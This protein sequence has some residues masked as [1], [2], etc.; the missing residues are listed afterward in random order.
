MAEK[1][2]DYKKL[3][4]DILAAVGGE[5]NITSV[6][7]CATRLRL[8]LKN[9]TNEMKE[10]V[11]QMP[12]VI[13]VVQN[14]GQFQIVIGQHVTD[15][16]D[17]FIQLV[18]SDVLEDTENQPKQSILNRVIATMSA[19]FAPFIYILAAAGI[20]QGLLIIINLFYSDFSKTGAYQVFSFMSWA[21][22]VFLP[23]FIAVTASKHFK[24]NTFV[25]LACCA[26]LVSPDWAN[27]AGQIA[28]GH[29]IDFFGIPLTQTVYTSSVIPPL[30]LVWLLSYLEKF[31]NKHVP[32]V[33]KELLVP[34]ISLVVMVPLTIILIGPISQWAANGVAD[35]YNWLVKIA[36]PVAG[37][38]IGGFWE[39]FVIFGV[40]WGITPVVL[41]NFDM[42]GMDSF[43]AFQTAAVVSQVGAALGVFFKSKNKELKTVSLSA[44][45]TGIFGI[46]E[47]TIY[48]VT[49]KFKRP[50]I[51][52]CITGALG[53]LT[54][55]LF[56]SH[57]FAYAGLPGMLTVVNGIS[58]KYPS[59]FIGIVLGCLVAFF[60][61]MILVMILG[62]GEKQAVAEGLETSETDNV[63]VTNNGTV[64]QATTVANSPIQGKMI[65]LAQVK[66]EV[67][68]SGA[69][70]QGVAFEPSDNKIYAPIDGEIEMF[71]DT[72]HAIGIKGNNGEE[73]LIHIGM[74]TVELKGEHFTSYAEVGQKVEKGDLLLEFDT[75]KIEEAGYSLVTP[76]IVTNADNFNVVIYPATE[77]TKDTEVLEMSRG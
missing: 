75:K 25:A 27:M 24:V 50:F 70:G 5:E 39:V 59:S 66:D 19:V 33:M 61:A 30:L 14:S 11:G 65:E 8:V 26:A 34:F 10:A 18:G 36:P 21:P 6:V 17:E 55:G 49:L 43:Q 48:G 9:E 38:I 64:A 44:F 37:A 76:M 52:A 51:Y 67:F 1:V 4:S 62:T 77:V 12:G 53:G 28:S 47:P 45:I 56:N 15:V 54:T 40:H 35:G 7:H 23:I 31:L 69:M 74:D 22:F 63:D 73:I 32:A 71:A 58:S 2:R 3:A 16:Y 41:A 13:T 46:T 57:Y 72:K 20:L 68:S 60:G 42:Y 29:A